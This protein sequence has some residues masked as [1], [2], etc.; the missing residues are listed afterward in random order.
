MNKAARDLLQKLQKIDGDNYPEVYCFIYSTI[1]MVDVVNRIL[2]KTV[3]CSN[4]ATPQPTVLY[5]AQLYPLFDNIL[6]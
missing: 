2:Q 4:S 6:Y 3:V 1:G 5:I